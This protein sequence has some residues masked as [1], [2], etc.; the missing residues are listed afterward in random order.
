MERG[1]ASWIK[2][3]PA[4]LIVPAICAISGFGNPVEIP[5]QTDFSGDFEDFYAPTRGGYSWS[6]NWRTGKYQAWVSSNN[7]TVTASM[8]ARALAGKSFVLEVTV[9]P[10]VFSG[11]GHSIG[12]AACASNRTFGS[13]YLADVKP[14]SSRFRI[15]KISG[16]TTTIAAEADIGFD[17]SGAE[18][19]K[20]TLTGD[21]SGGSIDLSLTVTSE[22]QTATLEGSDSS[23]LSGTYFGL[24]GRCSSGNFEF[25]FDDYRLDRLN[26]GQ[27]T[28]R[29]G[30]F[31]V[32]GEP[33]SHV[34]NG[35]QPD[36]IPSWAGLFPSGGFFGTPTPSDMGVHQVHYPGSEDPYTEAV[37]A[38]VV[39]LQPDE[40]IIS[41]FMADNDNT[42]KDEEGDSPDWIEIF[43]PTSSPVDLSGWHLTDSILER[44]KWTFPQGTIL[45]PFAFHIVFASGK[46]LPGH[47]SFRL[48]S[49]AGGYLALLRP[50]NTVVSE[51]ENYPTQK[52]DISFGVF[53]DYSEKG[54]LLE[55]SPGAANPST[56]VQGFTS[57][58]RFSVR[59][60]FFEAPFNVEVTCET[61]GATIVTTS[62][63]TEPTLDNGQVSSSPATIAISETTVLRAAAFA[64]DLA[65]TNVD[66]QTYLF[67]SDVKTQDSSHALARGWPSGSV[68]GQQFNYGMDPD[69]INTLGPGEFEEAMTQIPSLS[70]VTDLDNF[71]DPLTGFWV[72][73]ENRGRGWERPL[74]VELLDPAGAEGFQIDAGVRMRGGFSRQGSN[75]KHSFRLY[76][77]SEYGDGK[78]NY[79]LFGVNGTDEFDSLDLRTSQGGGGSWH[80]GASADATFN[81]DVF[82]RESQR[83]MGQPHTR[84]QHYHLYVNGQYFGLF[85]S[86]E[87]LDSDHAASYFGGGKDDYDV[88]KTRTKPHRVEA[89]DGDPDA[90][91]RLYDAAVAGF[92]NDAQYFAVQ[93]LDINGE[94][95]PN[96]D[97]L[98]DIDNLIDYMM[99]I[100]Y[101][102]QTDAPVNIGAN[103]PKNFYAMRPRDGSNGFRF[104]IHDNEDSLRNAGANVTGDNGTGAR[105]TYFNP[106]W[107]HQRLDAH[108]LYR[109][110]FGD[111]IHQ[112]FFN[113]GALTPNQVTSR[114]LATANAIEKAVIGESA[115]WGD[116][117]RG[118][119]YDQATWQGAVDRTTDQFFP[120]RS[121]TVLSQLRSRNLYPD[122]TAPSFNQ[123]GGQVSEGFPLSIE[124]PAGEIYYTIDGSDPADSGGI[125]WSDDSI[126]EP[127]VPAQSP[128]WRYLVTAVPFSDSEVV[129]G[130][131]G[132]GPTD[133]KHPSF[134]DGTWSTGTAPLGYGGV[135]SPSWTTQ[136][137]D[138]GTFPRNRTTYLRKSFQVA[139]ATNYTE[140]QIN[141]R[142]DDGAI[143][144]LNGR[145]IARSNMP[146]GNVAYADTASSG[147]T[148][149]G[150]TAY[151]GETFMLTP[152]I[153]V[154][155]ENMLAVEIHQEGDSSSDLVIDVELLGLNVNGGGLQINANTRVKSRALSGGEWS[156]LNEAEFFVT[157]PA[158]A[159]NLVVSEIYYNPPGADED[160]EYLEL[161]NVS[162]SDSIH[163]DGLGFIDGITFNFPPGIVM[164]PGERVLIV[165][166]LP[167]FEAAFGN[168][169]PVVGE[170][171]GNLSNGGEELALG[172]LFS[173]SF[174]DG[175]PWSELADGDG[176]SLVFVGGDPGEPGSWRAS[177][178]DGGSPGGSDA[179][180]FSGGDFRD[181][182][183][184]EYRPVL[185]INGRFS[186]V[187][188]LGADDVTYVVESSTDLNSW[189]PAEDWQV[190][191]ESALDGPY[192]SVQLERTFGEEREF[193]RVRAEIGSP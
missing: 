182:A 188:N 49:D 20:L 40:V 79:P 39:V 95:D 42:L 142:R 163:L 116:F 43:N 91:G 184:G 86:Q 32:V 38:E 94:V 19:F 13:Y 47:A 1:I 143:V 78:L 65:P 110:R 67:L 46:A 56:G 185:E 35:V 36:L 128:D 154:E 191:G 88:I 31:A 84:S 60:G 48:S 164:A 77:R 124:A 111:R 50:D 126:L 6:H 146:A 70:F 9:E 2:V 30:Q 148:G 117:Q 153:L 144:Y 81:R 52:E 158:S 193:L 179:T 176:R 5:Y 22:G 69:I 138:G 58:T 7:R 97:N 106:K 168:G 159:Q 21:R 186:F 145:E 130:H 123:H 57:D 129:E 107:L 161:L 44:Q 149:S 189:Q 102:G 71:I 151:F 90:W 160:T 87:R 175:A 72:N 29:P 136:I 122:V 166:N 25:Y 172:D 150:E 3:G 75:P 108:P 14:D 104:F 55:P 181:Y 54:F 61:P 41:E 82:A 155:G 89:L 114:F 64:P 11:S 162:E 133:W 27:P 26:I 23:P 173:F 135:G 137:S 127:L 34:G 132:Y 28:P 63:G 59:R 15:L 187:R 92:S 120:G 180:V 66:T 134:A 51:Y 171:E 178:S 76:F 140:L 83:D 177:V 33:F 24:R 118:T 98:V 96:G 141:I 152:G 139:G 167:A 103:V 157:E 147:A 183:F 121:N 100:F 53:G 10:V 170:Y 8:Q 192:V 119:P 45:E 85:Q 169:L 62:D 174:G 131:P 37:T 105:L 16:G 109:R 73:A 4:T 18:P 101:T 165:N 99:V 68:N 113:D 12:L 156:A 93:G 17:I 190:V 74:S 115:R 80:F 112:H 125:L